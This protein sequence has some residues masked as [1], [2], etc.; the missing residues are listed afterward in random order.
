MEVCDDERIS[1]A[2]RLF[3]DEIREKRQ[4]VPKFCGGTSK[5]KPKKVVMPMDVG[6]AAQRREYRKNGPCFVY[7]LE[8]GSEKM[9]EMISYDDFMRIEDG[10]E[11]RKVYM[12]NFTEMSD[13]KLA[14]MWGVKIQKVR[15][16]RKGLGV[17]RGRG[18]NTFK[19]TDESEMGW[20]LSD[21]KNKKP[22]SNIK[23]DKEVDVESRGEEGMCLNLE[24]EFTSEGMESRLRALSGIPAMDRESR[25]KIKLVLVEI[26]NK[27]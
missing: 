18:V 13:G 22:E 5:K 9:S 12:E 21:K 10:K 7:N 27:K 19:L 11:A 25:F 26:K 2:E 20:P 6:T 15:N 14:E 8:R 3:L 24:G 4:S 23:G 17:V 1:D 16:I